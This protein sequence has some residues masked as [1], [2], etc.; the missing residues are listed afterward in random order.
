MSDAET[1]FA[2]DPPFAFLTFNRPQARNAM[3]WAM[4][5]ALLAACETVDADPRVRVF[6][7]RG[8]GGKAFVSGTDISQF[9][10]FREHEAKAATDLLPEATV[11]TLEV[12]DL[13]KLDDGETVE[14]EVEPS[15]GEMHAERATG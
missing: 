9:Q 12:E 14:G 3:T 6:I 15:N 8:A 2:I 7:L 5:D 4:Y 10:S 1:I 11:S 13:S